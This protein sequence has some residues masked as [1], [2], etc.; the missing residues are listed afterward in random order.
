MRRARG[1]AVSAVVAMLAALGIVLVP[2]PAAYAGAVPPV[3][4]FERAWTVAGG[5]AVEVEYTVTCPDP[6][7]AGMRHALSTNGH[8]LEFQCG[9][10]PRRIVVLLHQPGSAGERRT[11]DTRVYSPQCMYFDSSELEPG[12]LGCWKVDVATETTLGTGAFRPESAVDIG[13]DVDL[14]R[15]RRTDAGALR[16]TARFSCSVPLDASPWFRLTQRTRAGVVA[17]EGPVRQVSCEPGDPQTVRWRATPLV[18]RF[19]KRDVVATVEWIQFAE[20]GPWAFHSGR[21]DV[22]A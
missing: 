8:Y 18:G 7:D 16:L 22:L 9:P 21:H 5:A 13:G 6:A 4:V 14:T 11:F 3:V 15:V 17:A 12:E 1:A 2:A 20:G 10:E 19:G